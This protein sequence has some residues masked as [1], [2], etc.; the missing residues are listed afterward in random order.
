MTR[1][2]IIDSYKV[3]DGIIRSPGK[4]EGERIYV[5]HFYDI[6]L[7]GF[8]DAEDGATWRFRVDSEDRQ[9]FP[10]LGRKTWVSLHESDS[11]F[12]TEV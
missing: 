7:N 11:G 5:P 2:D 1:K 4:F 10:E 12:V 8:A 3:I 9:A 6:G